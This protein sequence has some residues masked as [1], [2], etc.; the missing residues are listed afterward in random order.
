MKYQVTEWGVVSSAMPSSLVRGSHM[1]FRW[2]MQH[3]FALVHLADNC[4]SRFSWDQDSV[5]IKLEPLPL[6]ISA[7]LK[8]FLSAQSLPP[9]LTSY[10]ETKTG[11]S[12][13]PEMH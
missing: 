9:W 11:D 12:N 5:G 6:G 1:A 10:L 4:C 3:I 7:I 8:T 13:E 2:R